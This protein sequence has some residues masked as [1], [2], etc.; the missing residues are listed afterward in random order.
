MAAGGTVIYGQTEASATL[1]TLVFH[2]L[3][4]SAGK[5][6]LSAKAKYCKYNHGGGKFKQHCCLFNV[7]TCQI[8]LSS[9]LFIHR[10]RVCLCSLMRLQQFTSVRYWKW[11]V[12][13]SGSILI[14]FLSQN[15]K[16]THERVIHTWH[17]HVQLPPDGKQSMRLRSKKALHREGRYHINYTA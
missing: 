10:C 5:K 11:Y 15:V 1:Q 3:I 4:W 7:A 13:V 17:Q 8:P 2:S 12:Y 14:R 16:E 9:W 6:R